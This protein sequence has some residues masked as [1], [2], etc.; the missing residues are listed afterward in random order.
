MRS[1]RR[2]LI[3]VL[4]A[5]V[6]LVNFLAALNGYRSS[7]ATAD[8][9]FD[10]QL[11]HI[12]AIFTQHVDIQ[13]SQF[14]KNPITAFAFQVWENSRLLQHSPDAP[15]EPMAP[16]E[17]G[18]HEVNFNQAR[19]RVAVLRDGD[20]RWIEVAER[21]DNRFTLAENVINESILPLLLSVPI[22]GF[23]IWFIVRRG[24]LPLQ[25]LALALKQKHPDDLSAIC[26]VAETEELSQL[27]VSINDLLERLSSAL[28]RESRFAANA[29][30]ELRTPLSVLKVHIYNLRKSAGDDTEALSRL[31][32]GID[33]LSHMIEQI[34]ALHISSQDRGNLAMTPLNIAALCREAISDS[35]PMFT[36]KQQDVELIAEESVVLKHGNAQSLRIMIDN[37][38]TNAS[39]YAPQEGSIKVQVSNKENFVVFVI[40]D[41]GPGIP[42]GERKQV[43]ERFYRVGGDHHSSGETGC[44]LGLS[45]VKQVV[46]THKATIELGQSTQLGGLCIIV[47]FPN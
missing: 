32:Q 12:A 33:R 35:F 38:L 39:K 6:T 41:S 1:I 19:W 45:V 26:N 20:R 7:L 18:F 25:N 28:A 15:T 11:M 47:T 29:A 46:D 42:D 40:E 16:F 9:L 13:E 2:F 22:L 4:L 43:F 8:K 44:G 14:I 31:E 37:V 36:L 27:T 17:T 21:I 24:L 34:L 30:H 10:E 3:I 23:L 5:T